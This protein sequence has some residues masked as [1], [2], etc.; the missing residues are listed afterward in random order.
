MH[1][2]L[3]LSKW[4]CGGDGS[5]GPDDAVPVN[6]LHF[7][8]GEGST[9]L[10][11]VEGFSCCLGQFARQVISESNDYQLKEVCNGTLWK[12]NPE[13]LADFLASY[14]LSGVYDSTFVNKRAS[15]DVGDYTNTKLAYT[16]MDIN[17]DPRS[18]VAMKIH[19]IKTNLAKHG[20]T[21][22][23]VQ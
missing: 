23:V 7:M 22:E 3:S 6:E 10:E 12:N 4:R 20:H 18:P 8:R 14:D 13:S 21:L 17:D 9:K 2:V 5:L 15:D 11:N 19:L 16:L 1:Y